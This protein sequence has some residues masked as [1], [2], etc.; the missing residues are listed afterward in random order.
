[1]KT[2]PYLRAHL[3]GILVPT[4]FL[5]V[6]LAAFLVARHAFGLD[7]PVERAIVFP[8]AVV[9]NLWGLWNMLYL[10][11]HARTRLSLG[12]HGALLPLLLIPAGLALARALDLAW[13]DPKTALLL[14][15]VAIAVY[16]LVWEHVVGF[17]NGELGISLN[18]R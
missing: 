12:A 18:I 11:T 4:L 6:G 7:L 3:A 5:P 15:P 14:A 16:Y 9:P 2:H 10:A 17:L 13:I 8:M 1:M